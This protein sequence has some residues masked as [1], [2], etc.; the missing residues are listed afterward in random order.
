MP[1]DFD[2]LEREIDRILAGLAERLDVPPLSPAASEW[3]LRSVRASGA[4]WR[5]RRRLMTASRPVLGAVAAAVLLVLMPMRWSSEPVGWRDVAR[6]GP[7]VLLDDWVDAADQSTEQVAR[8]LTQEW[9][10]TGFGSSGSADED[11]DSLDSLDESFE[12][13]EQLLGA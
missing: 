3:L 1:D 13:I 2:N 4:Q 12:R 10:F 6:T 11:Y 9:M 8:I 5:S 7:D